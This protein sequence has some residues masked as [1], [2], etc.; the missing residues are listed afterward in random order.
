[1]A[2]QRLLGGGDRPGLT[3][4]VL[5][6]NPTAGRKSRSRLREA[7]RHLETRGV[8][9]DLVETRR[10]GDAEELARA[11]AVGR[12]DAVVAAG[13]DGTIHE[14]VNGLAYSS[15]PLGILP[16]GTANVF[17]RELG[18]PSDPVR[19]AQAVL[20]GRPRTVHLGRAGSR[21]FLVMAGVGFDAQVIYDLDLGLK[22]LLGKLAYLS[23]GLKVLLAP[24]RHPFEVRI[25]DEQLTACA[26]V[27]GKGHYWGGSF[28]VTPGARLE[29]PDLHLCLFT[30]S[31][32][33]DVLRYAGGIFS[34]KHLGFSDVFL[35]SARDF[36]LHSARPLRVQADGDLI[37]T[38]PMTFSVAEGALSVLGPP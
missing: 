14:V 20:A 30:G 37:G 19:A 36:A 25:G 28:Q 38:L 23:T 11:A 10:R 7:V 12:P 8:L 9:V 31:R 21:Y 4:V 1:M 13:G 17:A 22:R 18:L 26:A 27:I 29:D 16:L 5:I 24:P 6:S 35:R 33:W 3:R 32:P 2:D 15:V 34:G